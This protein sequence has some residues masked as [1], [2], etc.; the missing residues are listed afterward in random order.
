MYALSQMN[1]ENIMLILKK[2]TLK[3]NM[4]SI[5]WNQLLAYIIH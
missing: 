4:I 2:Q 3:A 1:F 5:T